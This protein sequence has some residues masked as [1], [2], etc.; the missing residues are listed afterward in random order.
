MVQVPGEELTLR[1]PAM[2][3]LPPQL[4][5]LHQISYSELIG[6]TLLTQ[7]HYYIYIVY[8]VCLVMLLFLEKKKLFLNRNIL[9]HNLE[10]IY[11]P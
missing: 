3:P 7:N 8:F 2:P 5:N 6:N 1:G 4:A 9:L 11:L 10:N